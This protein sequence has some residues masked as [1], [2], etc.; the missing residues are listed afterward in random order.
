MAGQNNNSTISIAG[1]FGLPFV[2]NPGPSLYGNLALFTQGGTQVFQVDIAQTG[3]PEL[4]I[5][6]AHQVNCNID[7]LTL[8]GVT[9][10]G[11]FVVT[12]LASNVLQI[13]N[14]TGTGTLQMASGGSLTLNGTSGL[15]L[16]INSASG[17]L[18]INGTQVVA[19]RITGWADPTNTMSRATFDTTTVTLPQLAQRVGQMILDIKTHGMFGT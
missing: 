9:L 2:I 12:F 16:N 3:S 18:K 13:A 1:G 19:A 4:I 10:A 11:A 8:T 17:T 14:G 6:T 15:N 5:S 7:N